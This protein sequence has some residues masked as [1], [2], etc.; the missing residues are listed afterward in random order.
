MLL[1]TKQVSQWGTKDPSEHQPSF[2]LWNLERFATVLPTHSYLWQLSDHQPGHL[3]GFCW[4][5]QP[6]NYLC[7][8]EVHTLLTRTQILWDMVFSPYLS[9]GLLWTHAWQHTG[10]LRA[11]SDTP[12][13]ALVSFWQL[14]ICLIL[15]TRHYTYWVPGAVMGTNLYLYWGTQG[16]NSTIS[17]KWWCKEHL[18]A[19][20]LPSWW[21]PTKRPGHQISCQLGFQGSF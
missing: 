1:V 8:K 12:T 21:S 18:L 20:V 9:L 10:T 15:A 4:S 7:S 11:L 2:V 3:L 14:G 16:A 19:T 13:L 5:L 6:P 17:P